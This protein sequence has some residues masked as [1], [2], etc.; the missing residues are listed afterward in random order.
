MYITPA[1][2]PRANHRIPPTKLAVSIGFLF[3]VKVLGESL[4]GRILHLPNGYKERLPNGHSHAEG[5]ADIE[6][7]VNPSENVGVAVFLGCLGEGAD[8]DGEVGFSLLARVKADEHHLFV[9]D[10]GLYSERLAFKHLEVVKLGLGGLSVLYCITEFGHGLYLRLFGV[11]HRP[12]VVGRFG[13]LQEG[14]K[15]VHIVIS[16]CLRAQLRSVKHI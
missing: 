2:K 15:R 14:I 7:A 9:P 3:F 1:I 12:M 8:F 4:G 6:I 13:F 11:V 10:I 16:P 5:V